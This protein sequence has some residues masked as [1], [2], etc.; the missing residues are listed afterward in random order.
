M[1]DL[2][3]SPGPGAPH[4]AT[5][6][7]KP[8]AGEAMRE[9]VSAQAGSSA[10]ELLQVQISSHVDQGA[11]ADSPEA[12]FED[13]DTSPFLCPVI[14]LADPANVVDATG[15]DVDEAANE[16]RVDEEIVM[17]PPPVCDDHVSALT[18]TPSPA[19]TPT[20]CR[21]CLA[22]VGVPEGKAGTPPSVAAWHGETPDS[23]RLF[24]SGE[25]ALECTPPDPG[26]P[27]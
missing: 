20:V 2:P 8:Q 15:V 24:H 16:E 17:D 13:A 18:P 14:Q 22:T 12:R 10:R 19:P 6:S 9:E 1:L 26:C 25:I 27:T 5:L 4:L 11:A 3:G 7:S 23:W 21:F